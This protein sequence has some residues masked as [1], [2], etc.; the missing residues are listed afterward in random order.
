MTAM[1]GLKAVAAEITRFVAVGV[2]NTLL[3]IG[4][5]QFTVSFTSPLLAY[6]VA[7]CVGIAIV[8][9]V[10]PS[11]V[12]RRTA[13]LANAGMIG[14]VYV[15]AFLIGCAVTALS[16]RLQIPDRAIIV[17][18]TAVT[19]SFTYLCGRRA[20]AQPGRDGRATL[21]R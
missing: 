15:V 2:G 1:L 8:M 19:S 7:W 11:L 21:H 5:Y 10:Y 3:T 17:I 20:L 16:A 12:F 14:T 4:V 6:L 18:A 13:T 9:L